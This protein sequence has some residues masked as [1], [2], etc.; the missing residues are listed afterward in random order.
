MNNY[1]MRKIPKH[2]CV[3]V[4]HLLVKYDSSGKLWLAYLAAKAMLCVRRRFPRAL[5]KFNSFEAQ[6]SSKNKVAQLVQILNIKKF[7]HVKKKN[8]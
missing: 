1:E 6:A 8:K 3:H 4:G 5:D 7:P 2:F